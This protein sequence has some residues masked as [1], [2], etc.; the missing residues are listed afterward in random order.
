MISAVWE[1][2]TLASDPASAGHPPILSTRALSPR[3][4]LSA[5]ARPWVQPL[6]HHEEGGKMDGGMEGQREGKGE[7]REEGLPT[8]LTQP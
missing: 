2:F 8:V 5:L 1:F 3:T 7:G 4:Q 6:A